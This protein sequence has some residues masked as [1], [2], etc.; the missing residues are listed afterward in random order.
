MNNYLHNF[1]FIFKKI[2]PGVIS[3]QIVH[4]NDLTK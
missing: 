4:N 3:N 1:I 2:I